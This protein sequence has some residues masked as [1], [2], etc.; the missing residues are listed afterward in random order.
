MALTQGASVWSMSFNCLPENLGIYL[1]G[2]WTEELSQDHYLSITNGKIFRFPKASFVSVNIMQME[3]YDYT[4]I[5][6]LLNSLL[7]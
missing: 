7:Y 2:R 3:N 1:Q 4:Y 6:W 5:A